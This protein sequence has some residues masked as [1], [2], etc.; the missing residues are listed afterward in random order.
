MT[1]AAAAAAVAAQNQGQTLGREAS[2]EAEVR[3]RAS[4]SDPH[5]MI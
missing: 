5:V 4:H 1:A 2:K 3:W